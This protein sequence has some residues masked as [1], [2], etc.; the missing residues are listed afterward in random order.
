M[1]SHG[2]SLFW[3]SLPGTDM[4]NINFLTAGVIKLLSNAEITFSQ[5]GGTSS[6]KVFGSTTMYIN[7]SVNWS[8]HLLPPV[9][10]GGV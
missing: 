7:G 10:Q 6:K 5:E 8:P 2:L 1:D 9:G 4:S 3:P